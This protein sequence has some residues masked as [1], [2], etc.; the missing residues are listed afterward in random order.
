[1]SKKTLPHRIAL[2]TVALLGTASLLLAGC[3]SST[4]T[5]AS[6]P[7]ES[8]EGTSGLFNQELHDSLPDSIQS[9]GTIKI[10]VALTDELFSN[11]KDGETSGVVVDLARK[12]GE[13]LGVDVEFVDTPFPGMIPALQAQRVDVIWSTM[14]DTVEREEVLDFVD[15]IRTSA[16]L[17][18]AKG[19]PEDIASIEDLCG[20]RAGT[21]RGAAPMVAM[22]EEQNAKCTA[23][24]DPAIDLKLYDDFV[25]GQ[26]QMRSGQIDAFFGPT[27]KFN[28]II[29]L[30]GGESGLEV[31]D[32]TYLGGVYGIGVSKDQSELS[33]ALLE[34][35]KILS[36][37]GTYMSILEE[38]AIEAEGFT[39][40][41]F[42]I[43]GIG[44]GAFE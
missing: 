33:D 11:Q 44:A 40:D 38:R 20:L 2:S 37:D 26:T 39:T 23:D 15:W 13:V 34:A 24:G 30:D 1:M 41:E 35:L 14:N 21:I 32:E 12:A 22:L 18:I 16:T 6:T 31:I 17:L 25:T 19:N 10:A 29:N 43:N 9:S 42:Q 28:Y 7:E 8:A 5:D 4:P 36:E 3:S 27:S